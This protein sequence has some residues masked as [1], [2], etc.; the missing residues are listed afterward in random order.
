MPESIKSRIAPTPSGYLHVGNAYNFLITYREAVIKRGGE[1]CLRIDDADQARSKDEYIN[2]IFESLEWLG[3]SIKNGPKDL[4]DFK[5]NHSQILKRKW[6]FDFL[7]KIPSTFN[8]SCSRKSLQ[9]KIC[10][11][12]LKELPFEK[13]KTSI[14]I[15][16]PRGEIILWRKEDIPSY[17][18]TSLADDIKMKI[19]LIVRGEDLKQ[20]SIEQFYISEQIKDKVFTKAVFIHH[21]LIKSSTGVKI[22]KSAGNQS[23]SD[24]SLITWRKKGAS[25]EDLI[26][27]LGFKSFED[28]LLK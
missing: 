12:K 25:T 22:S 19:N 27:H 28:F 5:N 23:P 16:S 6:Y 13:D 26:Q 17:H 3:I 15:K 10:S 24:D 1:L 21:P 7:K 4:Q 9:E 20:S 18:L 11:C 8:C 14:K 2:D